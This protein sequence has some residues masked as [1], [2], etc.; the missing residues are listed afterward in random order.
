MK[1]RDVLAFLAGSMQTPFIGPSYNLESRPASVQRTINM[2]PVPLEPGNERAPWVLKDV[3]GLVRVLPPPGDEPTG[4][5]ENAVFQDEGGSV[6]GWTAGNGTM[7]VPSDGYTRLT[8][9]AS[10][11]SVALATKTATFVSANRDWIMFGKFR[12]SR[13]TNHCGAIWFLNNGDPISPDANAA[14]WWGSTAASTGTYS[15]TAMSIICTTAG[16]T[17]RNTASLGT[18]YDY[19]TTAV[20]FALHYDNKWS[21]LNCFLRQ[22]D[23]TWLWKA[24]VA[25]EFFSPPN[26]Q[27][28]IAST[29]PTGAWVEFDYLL[30]CRPNIMS[31][32]DSICEGKTLFSPD[33]ALALTDPTSTYQ[34]YIVAYPSLRNNIVI[35]KGVGG[36]TSAQIQSRLSADVLVHS[37]RVVV[38]HAS[39]NDTVGAITL[40]DRTTNIQ[41][42]VT[43]I[44]AASMRAVL[45]NAVYGTS[46]NA[47]NPTLRDYMDD[48][49]NGYRI[50][51][52][53]DFTSV[54]IMAAI[55]SSGYMADALTQSDKIHPTPSGYAAIAP[56][57]SAVLV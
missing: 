47:L 7:S 26:I 32:G 29:A 11:G 25:G 35:N 1:R 12:A 6:D 48:W 56:L 19:E 20:E 14:I 49:W 55:I 27:M 16:G 37:P 10:T 23:G 43:A 2:V 34:R 3:P 42:C 24:R 41:A 45:L 36:Q 52:T 21:R 22:P 50:T 31:I 57:V 18:G 38:L 30:N 44:E 53:G 13:G 17:V 15:D 40:T 9:T 46:T 54:D 4:F 51:M 8:K 39:T 28:A 5:D 33:P